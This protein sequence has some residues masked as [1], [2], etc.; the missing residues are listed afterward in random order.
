MKL[1]FSGSG[2]LAEADLI[3]GTCVPLV[4]RLGLRL[5]AGAR[6]EGGMVHG[7]GCGPCARLFLPSF[8]ISVWHSLAAP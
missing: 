3:C 1:S 2:D 8:C 5:E 4:N 6:P 7:A